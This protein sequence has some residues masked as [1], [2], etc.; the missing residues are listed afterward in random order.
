MAAAAVFL[1]ATGI[2]PTR[3]QVSALDRCTRAQRSEDRV[4]LCSVAIQA[5]QGQRAAL[6]YNFRA[7]AYHD[8]YDLDRALT[9]YDQSIRLNPRSANA[10]NNRGIAWQAKG[11][12]DRAIADH[13][14]AI[15]LDPKDNS[16]AYRFRSIA[17][18]LKG[19]LQ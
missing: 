6:A 13:T 16:G 18:R 17:L 5:E 14:E 9:D 8:R 4:D 12:L 10:R 19:E 11:D 15:R 2:S 7:V 3:A 1:A